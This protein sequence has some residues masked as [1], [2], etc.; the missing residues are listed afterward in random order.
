MRQQARD[1]AIAT[2]ETTAQSTASLLA[3]LTAVADDPSQ[4][5]GPALEDALG[6]LEPGTVVVLDDGFV[7]GNPVDG[8][9]TLVDEATAQ[10][11]TV[12]G[13]VGSAWEIALP[14]VG[15]NGTAVVDVYVPEPELQRGVGSAWLLLGLLGVVLV[16]AA[17]F[18]ADRLGRRLV[19][20]VAELA[21][22]ANRMA[23]GDLGVRLPQLQPE[24]VGE[25]GEAFNYLAGRLGDLLTAERESVADLSHRLRTP[26]TSLRLQAEAVNE[27]GEREQLMSQVDRLEKAVSQL[28]E[29]ARNPAAAERGTC[30]LDEVVMNR[31][32]FW[33][34]LADSQRRELADDLN[35][36]DRVVAI[37]SEAVETVVDLLMENVFTHTPSGTPVE[38]STVIE[39][40]QAVL[41]V[42]D[43][44]PGFD[45]DHLE[46]GVGSGASTGLG[47]DIARRLAESAGGGLSTDD[48]PGGGA[49]VR[50][51]LPLSV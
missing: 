4:V 47:L 14:V 19:E 28:I 15:R 49:I 10:G 7:V 11:A 45:A 12:S 21:R 17:V 16:S 25:V 40:T 38:V 27:P 44:G 32:V 5:T 3:L 43:R 36:G 48:R 22:S 1:R 23:E 26:L 8:Q 46:R 2:A 13:P 6:I 9:L 35:V 42:A 37:G 50:A 39:S 33:S 34:V 51:R 24:E 20:P 31:L 29:S 30:R 41:E 18:L